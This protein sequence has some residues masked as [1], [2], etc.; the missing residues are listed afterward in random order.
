MDIHL[1]T[2][3]KT[4]LYLFVAIVAVVCSTDTA[5]AQTN[6]LTVSPLSLT[7]TSTAGTPQPQYLSVSSSTGNLTFSTAVEIGGSYFGVT[8]AGGTAA[9]D[10][11]NNV[12]VYI[13]NPNLLPGTYDGVIE[14]TAGSQVINVS[15][16]YTVGSGSGGGGA[17][18]VASSPSSLTFSTAVNGTAPAQTLTLSTTGAEIALT[19]KP[20]VTSPTGGTWLSVNPASLP[21]VGFNGWSRPG[22]L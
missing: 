13:P 12:Q 18:P 6:T 11:K 9:T 14:I 5:L 20:V 4:L 10:S 16:S 15:V 17:G 2:L 1:I 7:F 8:P 21:D 19:V 3:R 22:Q